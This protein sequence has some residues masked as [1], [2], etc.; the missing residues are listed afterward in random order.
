[1][2]EGARKY[3]PSYLRERYQLLGTVTFAALFSVLFLL[4]SIPFSNNAWFRLGN[5]TFFGFTALFASI[6]LAILIVSKVTMYKTRNILPMTYWG[7]AA[8][9]LSEIVLI[10]VLYTIFTVTI[11]Q[12]EDQNG[13]AI[14]FHA[15]VYTFVCL[16][17]PYIIAGMFF[18]IIDQNRT[19]RLMNMQDVVTDETPAETAAPV[20]KF[21]LF[22]NN[23]VL[24]LSVSSAN[25]YYVE[26]D[27]NYIKVWYADQQGALQ[28]Y[29]LR[30]RLKTVEESFAGSDLI[31][32][33]RKFI[34]NMQKVKVLQKVGAVY[35][36]TLDNEAIAPIPVTKTYIENVLEKFRKQ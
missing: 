4:V 18:T 12:P 28:T 10:T 20:Q 9:C 32:C 6:S 16:G 31:R 17:V 11:A 34:V 30:C 25:L 13:I 35:E 29:M 27:D 33:H 24:K 1:M 19:I 23:G 8:W 14:F 7:Y 26:A 5:S 22:D 15:L 2:E 3:I 36:I 21:T